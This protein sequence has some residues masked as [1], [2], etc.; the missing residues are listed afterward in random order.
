MWKRIKAKLRENKGITL[1]LITSIITVLI[2][3]TGLGLD[4]GK[5][6]IY[7][8]AL[9]NATDAASLAGAASAYC[10]MEVDGLG[11]VYSRKIYLDP[12]IAR[13]DAETVFYANTAQSGIVSSN[14]VSIEFLNIEVEGTLVKVTSKISVKTNFLSI[15][16][17][18]EIRVTRTSTAECVLPN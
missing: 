18:K 6:W 16:G 9:N 15:L 1:I 17:L 14:G 7:S 12:F 4:F 3:V 13:N 10:K 5:L 11:N 8:S 2:S